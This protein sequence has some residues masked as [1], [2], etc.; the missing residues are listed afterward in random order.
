VADLVPGAYVLTFDL[1]QVNGAGTDGPIVSSAATEQLV[2]PEGA[3]TTG[4]PAATAQPSRPD[5]L[6]VPF[7][8]PS[9]RTHW[10]TIVS[11]ANG[12]QHD[13]LVLS[14]RLVVSIAPMEN[15][16]QIHR[17]QLKEGSYLLSTSVLS[18]QPYS[19]TSDE[20]MTLF[21]THLFEHH[22]VRADDGPSGDGPDRGDVTSAAI[23]SGAALFVVLCTG[24]AFRLER[25]EEDR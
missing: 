18:F 5:T 19:L 20:G 22:V 11:V 17:P 6:D 3:L 15:Q 16:V 13:G 25:K 21:D 4:Q 14:E 1:G 12:R 9:A 10:G 24:A 23:V 7:E 8:N 2:L